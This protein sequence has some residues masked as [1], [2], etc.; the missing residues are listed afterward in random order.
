MCDHAELDAHVFSRLSSRLVP[1]PAQRLGAEARGCST[2]RS[3]VARRRTRR[4]RL[5]GAA[6]IDAARLDQERRLVT[7][8]RI[9][10]A[11]A[12]GRHAE[13]IPE[14]ERHVRDE[15]LQSA[16]VYS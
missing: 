8:E 13:L 7:E 3:C 1:L 15:P 11:L 12:L 6:Q 5:E 9:D 14:L 4:R 16:R 2:R 10:M